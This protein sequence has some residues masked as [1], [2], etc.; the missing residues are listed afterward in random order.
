MHMHLLHPIV[1]SV[2]LYVC[3]KDNVPQCELNCHIVVQVITS[4]S[5]TFFVTLL[6]FS[7]FLSS[8][9]PLRPN[10]KDDRKIKGEEYPILGLLRALGP[11]Y[12]PRMGS[13]PLIPILGWPLGP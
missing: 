2:L 7:I 11:Y 12:T 5:F 1:P 4:L 10:P 8:G 9:R 13:P 3:L 6:P